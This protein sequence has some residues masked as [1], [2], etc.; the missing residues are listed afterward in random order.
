[1]P[2]GFQPPL[3]FPDTVFNPPPPASSVYSIIHPGGIQLSRPEPPQL[4][5][6]NT[7]TAELHFRRCLR[8]KTS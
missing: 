8:D 1:M 3:F 7:K 6:F 4:L 2:V 5:P